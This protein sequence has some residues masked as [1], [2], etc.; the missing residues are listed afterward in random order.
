MLGPRLGAG[1]SVAGDSDRNPGIL[2][3][4]ISKQRGKCPVQG[5]TRGAVWSQVRGLARQETSVLRG[6]ES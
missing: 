1:K 2:A 6:G 3:K 5:D 4:A